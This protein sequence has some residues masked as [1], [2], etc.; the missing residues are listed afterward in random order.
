[1]KETRPATEALNSHKG[2]S[3]PSNAQWYDCLL[4]TRHWGN[5]HL[6][7]PPASPSH[8]SPTAAFDEVLIQLKQKQ[9]KRV[10]LTHLDKIKYLKVPYWTHCPLHYS[11]WTPSAAGNMINQPT[12]LCCLWRVQKELKQCSH[13]KEDRFDWV[14]RCQ[15]VEGISALCAT[16]KTCFFSPRTLCFNTLAGEWMEQKK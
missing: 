15:P 14:C 7:F 3:P 5:L 11:S 4:A 10:L 1:M 13:R 2:R 6:L 16:T 12:Q 9:K 8:R